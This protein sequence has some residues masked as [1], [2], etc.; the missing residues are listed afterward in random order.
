MGGGE[1]RPVVTTTMDRAGRDE[2]ELSDEQELLADTVF[3]YYQGLLEEDQSK[4]GT[5]RFDVLRGDLLTLS[6]IRRGCLLQADGLFQCPCGSVLQGTVPSELKKHWRRT[7]THQRFLSGVLLWR[8][9]PLFPRCCATCMCA[10]QAHLP[11]SLT[12]KGAKC[13]N[14]CDG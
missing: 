11:P 12:K 13:R 10:L 3:E 14:S 4:L 6:R 2:H 1:K 8:T 5:A 7:V 9:V